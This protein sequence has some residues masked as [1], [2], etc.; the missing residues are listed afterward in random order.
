MDR[1]KDDRLTFLFVQ[2]AFLHIN[3]QLR[4]GFILHS[5]NTSIFVLTTYLVAISAKTESKKDVKN[6]NKKRDKEREV[7]R[8]YVRLL[9]TYVM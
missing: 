2:F 4:Q 7:V 5:L 9:E 1:G 8:T 6:E 3:S